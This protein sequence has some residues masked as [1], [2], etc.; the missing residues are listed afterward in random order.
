MCEKI[1]FPKQKMTDRGLMMVLVICSSGFCGQA[2]ANMPIEAQTIYSYTL[3]NEISSSPS[4]VASVAFLK[5][6]QLIDPA[7]PIASQIQIINL[8]GATSLNAAAGGG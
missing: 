2:S 1:E 8:P 5:R 3:A 4:T 6:P 7:I